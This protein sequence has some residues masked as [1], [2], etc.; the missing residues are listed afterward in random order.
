MA[1]V[2]DPPGASGHTVWGWNSLVEQTEPPLVQPLLWHGDVS[3]L[4]WVTTE[5]SWTY[6]T[7]YWTCST[8]FQ[9]EMSKPSYILCLKLTLDTGTLTLRHWSFISLTSS[10]FWTGTSSVS[11]CSSSS[12]RHLV[13][14]SHFCLVSVPLKIGTSFSFC[15][16]TSATIDEGRR[17]HTCLSQF[18]HSLLFVNLHS[19]SKMF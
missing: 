15:Q 2:S 8:T 13:T 1:P 9:K 12:Y 5:H 16:L 11:T 4:G 19:S 18:Q 7:S 3:H 10:H 6:L 14:V 17:S